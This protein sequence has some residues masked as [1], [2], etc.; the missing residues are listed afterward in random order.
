MRHRTAR[1]FMATIG[2]CLSCIF[3]PAGSLRSR[4]LFAFFTLRFAAP[5]CAN[6]GLV[7]SRRW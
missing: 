4:A 2:N 6:N 7:L 3:L 5:A 1:P